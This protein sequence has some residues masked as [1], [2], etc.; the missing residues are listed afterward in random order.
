L[1]PNAVGSL[2]NDGLGNVSWRITA[3]GTAVLPAN[4]VSIGALANA[5]GALTNDGAGNFSYVVAA[6]TGTVTSVSVTSGNGFAGTVAT[7]TSTP[8][9]TLSTTITGLLK[10]NG[11]AISAASPGVDYQAAGSYQTTTLTSAHIL[12]G[13]GSNVATDVALSGDAALSNT[14]VLGVNKTRLNVRN[15]TGITIASTKVVY[16]NG[17]NNFPL[18]ALADN[19]DETKH[20]FVG[21][22]VAPI[23]DSSNGYIA[24]TGQCDAE[25]NTWPVGTQLF[26]TTAGD[27]TSTPPTTGEVRHIGYVTVQQ[28]YP[29]GKILLETQFE[30]NTRGVG[31]NAGIIDR[32]GDSAGATKWSL[33][34]YA[35]T[36]VFSI[37]SLGVMTPSPSV[38][39]KTSTITAPYPASKI[40]NQT[41]TDATVSPTSKII[42]TLGAILDTDPTCCDDLDMISLYAIPA[43]GSF[44]VRAAFQT[45][46]GGTLKLNYMVA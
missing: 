37:D 8:A 45:P 7:A 13:N 4:L 36:E 35:N 23:A 12:V 1:L 20:D 26:Y 3:G 15:E 10:G 9:I 30:N 6:G 42:L 25:T 16:I 11:T 18:I 33:R 2:Y 5:P 21:L 22:T 38:S 46:F 34:N 40:V 17:F 24:T 19:T 28:N 14:G 39:I 44:Q 31:A 29:T 27:I 43:A 41:V 32:L